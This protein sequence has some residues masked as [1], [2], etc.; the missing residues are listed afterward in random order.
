[1]RI[2]AGIENLLNRLYHEHLTREA[3][4]PVGDLAAG[5]EIPESGRWAYIQLRMTW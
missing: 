5:D 3:L 2:E 1:L 4:M